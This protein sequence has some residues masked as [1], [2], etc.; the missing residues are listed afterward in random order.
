LVLVDNKTAYDSQHNCVIKI[1]ERNSSESNS[2]KWWIQTWNNFGYGPWSDATA[3][4]VVTPPCTNIAGNWHASETVTL[5]RLSYSAAGQAMTDREFTR[6][7]STQ[8]LNNC[9]K[10]LKIMDH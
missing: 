1:F 3:Y 7:S 9:Y 6:E 8:L 5:T 10:I 2:C 4:T